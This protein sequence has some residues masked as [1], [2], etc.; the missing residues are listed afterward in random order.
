M[1]FVR[2]MGR[3]A[4]DALWLPLMIA[5]WMMHGR[6]MAEIGLDALYVSEQFIDGY[7]EGTKSARRPETREAVIAAWRGLA[8]ES[9]E[10]G[11]IVGVLPAIK[12]G[13]SVKCVPCGV[14]TRVSVRAESERGT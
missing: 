7:G 6:M 3:A 4:D 5:G 13:G 14:S 12:R 8:V 2:C 1:G 11:Q 10:G 9:S